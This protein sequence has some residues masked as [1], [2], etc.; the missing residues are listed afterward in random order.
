GLVT[1]PNHADGKITVDAAFHVSRH[2][3]VVFRPPGKDAD[4][5]EV[6]AVGGDSIRYEILRHG[7]P[8]VVDGVEDQPGDQVGF[9]RVDRD[10][11]RYVERDQASQYPSC[12]RVSAHQVPSV[13]GR[14]GLG[15]APLAA[16]GRR[17]S[18]HELPAENSTRCFSGSS[19]SWIASRD[20]SRRT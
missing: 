17:R 7:A 8:L 3:L 13:P 1:A 9:L 15:N 2:I 6:E 10:R 14:F 19:M 12:F 16:F 5:V 11:L 4:V 20:G 18:S